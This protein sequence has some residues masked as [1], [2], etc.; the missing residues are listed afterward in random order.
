MKNSE[1]QTDAGVL[2]LYSQHKRRAGPTGGVSLCLYIWVFGSGLVYLCACVRGCVCVCLCVWVL[3]SGF[4]YLCVGAC[5][6][7]C[8]RLCVCACV[9]LC[10]SF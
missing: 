5:V 6:C 3:G 2:S 9:C 10:V 4:M 7:L 8:V 1:K